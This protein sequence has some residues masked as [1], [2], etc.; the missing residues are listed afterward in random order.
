M[1]SSLEK[2]SPEAMT[3]TQLLD[4]YIQDRQKEYRSEDE[5]RRF[6]EVMYE[7]NVRCAPNK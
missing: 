1:T 2:F 3:F 7:L 6:V 5:T 4:E